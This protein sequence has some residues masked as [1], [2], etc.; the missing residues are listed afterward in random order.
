MPESQD[1]IVVPKSLVVACAC[2]GKVVICT[3]RSH[4]RTC[5]H[6]CY[7]RLWRKDRTQA[8][9]IHAEA[10]RKLQ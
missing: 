6:K 3:H 1:D 9:A 7:M 8:A 4:R 5:S 2:C 10:A